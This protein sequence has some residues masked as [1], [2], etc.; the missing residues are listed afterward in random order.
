MEG[1]KRE[2][3]ELGGRGGGEKWGERETTQ[4]QAECVI[5]H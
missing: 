2:D 1:K 3:G 4:F 5:N